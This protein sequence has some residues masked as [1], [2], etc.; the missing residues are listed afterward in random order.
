MARVWEWRGRVGVTAGG[1]LPEGPAL[2]RLLAGYPP[3][4]PHHAGDAARLTDAQR[5]DNLAQFLSERD[6]RLGVVGTFL[7][8]QG[9][10]PSAMLDPKAD[11][12][13]AA[14]LI[15]A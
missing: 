14:R 2:A 12:V 11:G 15:D 7:R 13:A 5:D 4:R 10:D 9:L 1:C 3:N 6:E 8:G